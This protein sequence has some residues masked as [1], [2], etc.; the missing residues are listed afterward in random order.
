MFILTGNGF[1]FNRILGH[2]M[3]RTFPP[4]E[5]MLPLRNSKQTPVHMLLL[6]AVKN[7]RIMSAD[8]AGKALTSVQKSFLS[9]L[10]FWG[11]EILSR[12]DYEH[13]I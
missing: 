9:L 10:T 11:F 13:Q 12:T 3:T 5:L 6:I 8:D 4:G 7:V 2:V 1:L